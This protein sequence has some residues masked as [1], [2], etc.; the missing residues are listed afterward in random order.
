MKKLS[1]PSSLAGMA[2]LSGWV[3]TISNVKD[4]GELAIH[5]VRINQTFHVLQHQQ[6]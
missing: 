6:I 1:C 4:N 5:E 3:F 2:T